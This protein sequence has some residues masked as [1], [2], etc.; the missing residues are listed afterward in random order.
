MITH[1]WLQWI[2]H[3]ILSHELTQLCSCVNRHSRLERQSRQATAAN[4]GGEATVGNATAHETGRKAPCH[5]LFIQKEGPVPFG[6]E[7]VLQTCNASTALFTTF[8]LRH[9]Q[10]LHRVF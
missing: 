10:F 8:P 4:L 6:A 9:S 5:I 2:D 7:P 3:P 1:E